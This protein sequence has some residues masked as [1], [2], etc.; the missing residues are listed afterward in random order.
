M[1]TR[2]RVTKK[3]GHGQFRLRYVGSGA[4]VILSIGGAKLGYALSFGPIWSCYLEEADHE[5]KH[6]KHEGNKA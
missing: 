6:P 4:W 2:E 1:N 3:V 5:R